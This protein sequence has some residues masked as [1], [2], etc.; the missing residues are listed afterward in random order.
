MSKKEKNNW[1]N[2]HHHLH[3]AIIKD[4]KFIPNGIKLLIAVSG[5]QDSMA[6]LALFKDI[7]DYHDWEIYVWHGD[8]LL[9]TSPS[10]RDPM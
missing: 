3:K 1:T 9:Y 5:G 7:K 6:L 2:W 8:C 10:P 4:A